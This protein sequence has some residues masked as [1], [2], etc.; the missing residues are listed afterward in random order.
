VNDREILERA[1]ALVTL[2]MAHP[3]YAEAVLELLSDGQRGVCPRALQMFELAA[4]VAAMHDATLTALHAA[5]TRSQFFIPAPCP[6]RTHAVP[7]DNRTAG[8]TVVPG[9]TKM[10][11]QMYKSAVNVWP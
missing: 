4:E 8:D 11:V 7:R 3:S 1:W 6:R 10:G 2:P 9:S 5:W